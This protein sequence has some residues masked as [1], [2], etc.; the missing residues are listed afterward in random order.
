MNE[1]VAPCDARRE[2]ISGFSGS[3][4]VALIELEKA[5]MFTDGRYTL[6]ASS[7]LDDNWQLYIR[8][9]T[10]QPLWNEYVKTLPKDWRIGVDASTI[11]ISDAKEL[12]DEG[13]HLV[14]TSEN[15]VDQVWGHAR[16]ARPAAQVDVH[17]VKYAGQESSDKVEK[18]RQVLAEKQAQAL[19][20][21]ALDEVA[22]LLN[23][24]GGLSYGF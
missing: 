10:G 16:P 24:R 4:G 5:T 3:A 19:V 21:A 12:T 15:L 13:V 22:W 9:V 11:S 6:Q 20:V 7:Q 23:L 17:D 2:Y 8:G 1:K 18:L 14:E